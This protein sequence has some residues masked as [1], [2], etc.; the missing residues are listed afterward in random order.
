MPINTADIQNLLRPGLKTVFG[1][2]PMYPAQFREI[3][4][5]FQ[6]DK[7]VEIDVE[8]K[9]LGLAQFRAEG[10]STAMDTMGQRVITNYI[11]RYVALG[12][13]I[14]RQCMMDNLYKTQFPQYANAL[15]DSLLQFKELNGAA[16]LN[17]G[18]D[19]NF[20]GGDGQ[21]LFSLNHPIDTGVYANTPTVAADLNEASLEQGII[22]VQQFRNQAGLIVMTKPRKLIVGPQNQFVAE[23]LLN[24]AF[25]TNTANNDISA[26]FN[27][28]SVPENY[29]VNQY[30]TQYNN[31]S[32]VWFLI[33]DAS[34]GFKYMVREKAETDVY[35]DFTTDNLQAKAVERYSFNYSNAR[36]A[37]GSHG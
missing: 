35:T 11:H 4:T 20:P 25:R 16:V 36:C 7:A 8:M 23:R 32:N 15:R 24:S 6:S 30:I 13:T 26:V 18:F 14:T 10:A 27:M 31:V 1:N 22:A 33:T 28:S 5:E 19:V 34:D 9:F 12:F 2:Y 37:Y 17:N 29:K 21:P 3:F